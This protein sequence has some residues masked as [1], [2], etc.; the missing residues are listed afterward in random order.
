MIDVATTLVEIHDMLT[1]MLGCQYSI[2]LEIAP[3]KLSILGDTTFLEQVLLNLCTN[4][5]DAMPQGGAI[6]IRVQLAP[7]TRIPKSANL[8]TNLAQ[9]ATVLLIEVEDQGCGIGKS[10]IQKVLT[11]FFTTKQRGH[12]TGLGLATVNTLVQRHNGMMEV[13]SSEG[14]GTTIR[15]Y[16]PLEKSSQFEVAASNP[17][18]IGEQASVNNMLAASQLASQNH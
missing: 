15:V 5:R 9:N 8:T 3:G 16:L 13:K 17:I 7:S 6:D 18:L 11:P 14:K 12:G 1:P 10:D 2:N 4:A